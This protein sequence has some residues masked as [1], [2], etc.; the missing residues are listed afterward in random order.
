MMQAQLAYRHVNIVQGEFRVSDDPSVV[1]TTLLGSC[2]AACMHDPVAGVGGMNHFLL[3]ETSSDGDERYGV[4]LMEL[5]TNGL[6]QHGARKD[7][8]QAKLFGGAIVVKG[9]SNVG[10]KNAHF[11]EHCL[12]CEG[13]ALVGKSTGGLRGRRLQF[14]PV[15]GRARQAFMSEIVL[16]QKTAQPE[17]D[18]SAGDLELF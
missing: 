16:P 5:L 10:A 8:L 4:H 6:M 1:L 18:R 14:W 13:I 9:L 3:P 17:W 7:R 12:A 15:S 11:A 2:I